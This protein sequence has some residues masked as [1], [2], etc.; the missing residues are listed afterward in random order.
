MIR[1]LR[2]L[3][4]WRPPQGLL[5][6]RAK[7]AYLGVSVLRTSNRVVQG[8]SRIPNP[9]GRGSQNQ[10]GIISLSVQISIPG[11]TRLRLSLHHRC[12]GR[13]GWWFSRSSAR[14]C[15][16]RHRHGA[17]QARKRDRAAFMSHD[18]LAGSRLSTLHGWPSHQSR[19]VVSSLA[20]TASHPSGETATERTSFVCPSKQCRHLPLATSHNL[21][22]KSSLPESA[23]SPSG[24]NA[25]DVTRFRCSSK[26]C[27]H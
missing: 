11:S 26:L 18:S 24:E 19:S 4:D 12:A 27:K 7:D 20:D 1:R 25:T 10:I 6:I 22:V 2:V 5:G 21:T 3:C 17:V 15:I 23:H 8:C 14:P 16:A 13:R 9:R